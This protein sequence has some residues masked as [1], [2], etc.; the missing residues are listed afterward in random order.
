MNIGGIAIRY[1]FFPL[2]GF[3]HHLWIQLQRY[4]LESFIDQGTCAILSDPA[5]SAKDDMVA[6]SMSCMSDLILDLLHAQCICLGHDLRGNTAIQVY[7][8]RRQRHTDKQRRQDDLA[9]L[10]GN[11]ITAQGEREY[12]KAELAPLGQHQTCTQ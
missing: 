2:N 10:R 9:V 5:V 7:Q 8:Y 6:Q 12:G 1:G 4:T 11:N 3:L